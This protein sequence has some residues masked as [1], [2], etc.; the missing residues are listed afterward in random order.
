MF[1]LWRRRRLR[2]TGK[3]VRERPLESLEGLERQAIQCH[4]RRYKDVS[5]RQRYTQTDGVQRHP[6]LL[7]S[8][9]AFT[10]GGTPVT[11]LDFR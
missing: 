9:T 5:V 2:Y 6:N 10:L 11:Q 4:G 7:V 1:S 8:Y 3:D